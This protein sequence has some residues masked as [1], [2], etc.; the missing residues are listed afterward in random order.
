MTTSAFAGVNSEIL[1]FVPSSTITVLATVWP[2]EKLRLEAS[3]RPLPLGQT[4]RND[5]AA[6]LVTVTLRTTAA[7]PAGGPPATPA[8]WTSLI[9]APT[10]DDPVR[11]SRRR[12]GSNG[13]NEVPDGNQ[14][15]TSTTTSTLP[16]L[17]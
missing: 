13:L 6:G 17:L 10:I 2:A 3:G 11:V 4:V 15:R 9:T 12:A 8:I 1:P 5:A 14:P 16:V 7:A